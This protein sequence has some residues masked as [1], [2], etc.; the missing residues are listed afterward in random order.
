LV[1]CGVF[2][3]SWER[4]LHQAGSLSAVA[5]GDGV[6]VAHERHN[7]LVRVD[8]TTGSAL[9]E[10]RVG[11]WPRSVAIA[12]QRCL[13]IPQDTDR[14]LCLDLATGEMLWHNDLRPVTG[15][16]TI[17]GDVVYVGGWRGYTPIRAVDLT[18]GRTLA[19]PVQLPDAPGG[20]DQRALDLG[21]GTTV[22]AVAGTLR[23]LNAAGQVV[24]SSRVTHRI[25]ALRNLAPGRPLVIA[26]G[27]LLAIEVQ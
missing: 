19:E 18:T 11:T 3:I 22:I 9:W 25:R 1:H 14:L 12:D 15:G 10:A 4:P 17:D 7:R 26:K 20:Q 21:D 24:E 2:S 8:P 5:I 23:R 6:L 27:S 13:V 16:I